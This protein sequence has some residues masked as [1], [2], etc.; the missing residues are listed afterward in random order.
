MNKTYEIKNNPEDTIIAYNGKDYSINEMLKVDMENLNEIIEK[1]C[2]DSFF[3][4][5]IERQILNLERIK[6]TEIKECESDLEQEYSRI[7]LLIREGTISVASKLTEATVKEYTL[8]NP[9]YVSVKNKLSKLK[10]E[11]NEIQSEKDY[12]VV[13]ND[14]LKRKQFILH[15]YSINNRTELELEGYSKLKQ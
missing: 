12:F 11:Y 9:D 10:K 8:I 5:I 1:Y 6:L 15:D 13:L 14:I 2:Y 4:G 7:S 3:M